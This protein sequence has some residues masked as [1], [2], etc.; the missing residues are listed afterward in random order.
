MPSRFRKR[1]VA[2]EEERAPAAVRVATS[3]PPVT[4]TPPVKVLAPPSTS[5]PPPVLFS[6]WEP[7]TTASTRAVM[8]AVSTA[9]DG[10]V[11]LLSV[12]VLAP[13]IVQPKALVGLSKTRLPIVRFVSRVTVIGPVRL[14]VV[15]FAVLFAPSATVPPCQLAAVLQL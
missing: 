6:P 7:A 8:P 13:P 1:W 11:V 3:V 14:A 2:P 15:K 4:V 12:S 10:V 5:V 9:I